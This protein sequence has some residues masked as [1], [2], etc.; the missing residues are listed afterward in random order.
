MTK[1]KIQRKGRWKG[2]RGWLIFLILLYGNNKS[3]IE[4]SHIRRNRPKKKKKKKEKKRKEKKPMNANCPPN[5]LFRT[6]H[7]THKPKRKAR[8]H[9][10]LPK[11]SVF[12]CAASF[13]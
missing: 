2:E 4:G 7:H 3:K 8:N 6:V 11:P 13:F 1:K 9:C 12:P 5:R 10:C